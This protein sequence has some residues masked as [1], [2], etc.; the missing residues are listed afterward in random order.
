MGYHYL[1]YT[2]IVG[3]FNYDGKVN[4]SDLLLFMPYWPDSGCDFPDWC[5]GRDLN[6][7]GIVNFLDEAIFDLNYG[8]V[9]PPSPNPM[10]WRQPP[11]YVA[12]PVSARMKATKAI[13]PSGNAVQYYFQRTNQTGAADGM[14][15]DWSTDA[16]C[17]DTTVV[18]GQTYGYRV[19]ARNM[20]PD[21]NAETGWST[22]AYVIISGSTG[23]IN[24][25]TNLTLSASNISNTGF[26]LTAG[27]RCNASD[28]IRVYLHRRWRA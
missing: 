27:A 21:S 20:Q 6:Q 8:K 28:N 11:Y 19:K 22:I 14:Y 23:D 4:L 3:D 2:Y 5:D 25:P 16:N 24:P 15:R 13:N 26:T 10:T 12:S 1:L 9:A 18:A 7:D 17:V